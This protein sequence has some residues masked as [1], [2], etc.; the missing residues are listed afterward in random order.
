MRSLLLILLLAAAMAGGFWFL[1]RST[2][3]TASHSGLGRVDSG[4]SSGPSTPAN[5]SAELAEV[6]VVEPTPV[7]RRVVEV[8]AKPVS[9]QE[10]ELREIPDKW[11]VIWLD[12]RVRF[13]EGT[14]ADDHATIEAQGLTF[15]L[16]SMKRNRHV[17]DVAP[18]GRF[19]VAVAQGTKV[20][21]FALE[22][23][24]SFLWEDFRYELDSG[25]PLEIAA[26][27]GAAQTLRVLPPTGWKGKMDDL[28]VIAAKGW[29]RF[30]PP[31]HPLPLSPAGELPL[32][33][34]SPA[35][36]LVL[37]IQGPGIATFEE[38]I[39]VPAPGL[40]PPLEVQLTLGCIVSGT[41]RDEEGNPIDGARLTFDQINHETR[42]LDSGLKWFP[43]SGYT[44][45]V[46]VTKG[47]FHAD[48]LQPAYYSVRCS[49]PGYLHDP[50][51]I[52][53]LEPGRTTTIDLQVGKGQCIE[54]IVFWPSGEPAAGVSV[55]LILS[56]DSAQVLNGEINS[57]TE[58]D[59]AGHFRISGF[60]ESEWAFGLL[61]EGVPPDRV[62]P[63]G[64]S[65][66]KARRWLRENQIECMHP[67]VPL[68]AP[69]IRFVMQASG[70]SV[71]G[72]VIDHAGNP[73]DRF[74]VDLFPNLDPDGAVPLVGKVSERFTDADGRFSLA[75]VADGAWYIRANAPGYDTGKLVPIQIPGPG[76]LQLQL[77]GLGSLAGVVRT[78]DGRPTLGMVTGER[79]QCLD[80]TEPSEGN[81]SFALDTDESGRFAQEQLPPGTWTVSAFGEND[82]QSEAIQVELLPGG[83]ARS[84]VLAL[85]GTGRIAGM[86][87]PGWLSGPAIARIWRIGQWSIR[88]SPIATDGSFLIE[89]LPQGEYQLQLIA[90]PSIENPELDPG[91]L[92]ETELGFD[93]TITVESGHTTTVV[94]D[95]PGKEAVLV[96]GTVREGETA[97]PMAI[98]SLQLKESPDSP[99]R[100]TVTDAMGNYSLLLSKPG[101]YAVTVY[102]E[103]GYHAC[104]RK[105]PI[106]VPASSSFKLDL[107]VPTGVLTIEVVL[108]A[109]MDLDLSSLSGNLTLIQSTG[110]SFQVEDQEDGTYR[111]VNLEPGHY[112]LMP[113]ILNEWGTRT[114]TFQEQA[115][116]FLG[117]DTQIVRVTACESGSLVATVDSPQEYMPLY[118][119]HTETGGTVLSMEFRRSGEFH[120]EALPPGDIWLALDPEGP[121]TKATIRAGQE[122][123]VHI[124]SPE[125]E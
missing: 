34:L 2:D 28:E 123:R 55:R 67:P 31:H 21:N 11:K 17:V 118:A 109:D 71:T 61:F 119:F 52:G 33:G 10:P 72:R 121:R 81:N 74:R 53:P 29:P 92:R 12:G 73:V 105:D 103:Q 115:V 7:E 120:F 106:R 62:M 38:T 108:S 113:G 1:H 125:Q 107:D 56:E 45:E 5:G 117:G 20:V 97:V 49:K 98:V 93:R 51:E 94:F 59:A 122:S 95:S 15:G 26:E 102:N 124:T 116:H 18:D 27:F 114:F 32:T 44:F 84:I 25:E 79:V 39:E 99:A 78:H 54:G 46:P 40:L 68:D 8:Q 24:Y 104:M 86:I 6:T 91:D 112:T 48:T 75:S 111:F 19:R 69:P 96:Q 3:S 110:R 47:S 13:Q 9:A 100:Q 66:L 57:K 22:A 77:L 16:D 23:R 63:E 88:E 42:P 65:R 70:Q 83:E 76:D 82:L 36:G 90:T 35:K 30:G 14:P 50:E 80:G 4:P 85:E 64:L 43:R 87:H 89:E 41:V 60:E 37:F 58:T 101:D